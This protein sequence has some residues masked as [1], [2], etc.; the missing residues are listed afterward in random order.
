MRFSSFAIIS[1]ALAAVVRATPSPIEKRALP[2]LGG[3]NIAGFDFG[4]DTNGGSNP[5]TSQI[6]HFVKN[7]ANV[8]RLPFG[9]NPAVGGQLGG[10]LNPSWFTAYD[11]LVQ[12]TL[13]KGAYAILDLHNYARWNGGIVGQGGP[14]D[15]QLA[16]VWEQ[17][18]KKYSSNAKV[19]FGLMN[20]PHDIPNIGTFA[21]TLQVSVN[22]IRSAGATS[23]YILLP[24]QEWTHAPRWI[25]GT[26]DPIVQ[27]TDPAGGKEKLLLDVHQYLDS[28]G[29]GTHADC[30]TDNVAMMNNLANYLKGKGR[31]AILSETGAGPDASCKTA[32]AAQL[33]TVV[34]QSSSIIGFVIW[35]GGAFD[36]SYVLSAI[37][38]GNTDNALVAAAVNPYLP[39]GA[40]AAP[41]PAP[42]PS[43]TSTSTRVSSSS[44]V[45]VRPSSS[46][47]SAR[48]TTTSQAAT[49]AKPTTTSQAVTPPRPTTTSKAAS[50]AA[51]TTT[52]R[53]TPP[54]VT[55][56]KPPT[57]TSTKPAGTP[58][59][60]P[61]GGNLQ[62]YT[63]ALG[64]IA[65]PPVTAS[66]NQFKEGTNT[67]NFLADALRRSCDDQSNLC[68]SYANS[69]AGRAA[70]V[71]INQCQSQQQTAC[72]QSISA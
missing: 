51:P 22:A 24:G 12:Y 38:N 36:S 43:S 59:S 32:L 34:D 16:S 23:Q 40:G 68:G 37:P 10:T 29:S 69:A 21:K 2:R 47:S 46:S 14:T 45:A 50:S 4:T 13:S 57:S 3:F 7:G 52:S 6:D 30:T 48:P 70:G 65:A 56:S 31:Q 61:A 9:W 63:G 64:G 71:S 42:A 35:S 28:D 25:D 8:F 18:A 19:I 20:E 5:A 58:T 49:S 60:L 55:S 17:L 44:A 33:K 39:G 53:S 26:N 1:T 41:A 11:K 15:A 27:I 67:F 72:Y 66:G 54:A 62:K